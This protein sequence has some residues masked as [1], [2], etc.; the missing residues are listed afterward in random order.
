M[1]DIATGPLGPE[2]VYDV[3]FSGGALTFTLKYNG[4]QASVSLA[5]S[6]SAGQMMAALAAKLTNPLEKEFVTL[7]GSV[8]SSIP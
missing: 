2:A 7:L 4:A 5:G 6:I 8:I 1:A 3:A